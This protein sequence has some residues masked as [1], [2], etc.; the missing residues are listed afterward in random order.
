MRI[1]VNDYAGHPF[2]LQLSRA[3]AR[4][5]HTVPH[6]YFAAFQTPKGSVNGLL[7]IHPPVILP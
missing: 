5:G 6:T 1:L 4:R 2:E 3:L 7:A